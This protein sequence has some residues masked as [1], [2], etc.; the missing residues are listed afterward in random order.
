[1]LINIVI[2]V[3]SLSITF[4]ILFILGVYFEKW[5]LPTCEEVGKKIA[6]LVYKRKRSAAELKIILFLMFPVFIIIAWEEIDM[7]SYISLITLVKFFLF[8]MLTTT[9]S[10]SVYYIHQMNPRNFSLLHRLKPLFFKKTYII[11]RFKLLILQLT[12][13]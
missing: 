13:I 8:F 7:S 5:L 3:A 12:F 4:L 9:V 10:C 11:D 1:M 2:D 6:N